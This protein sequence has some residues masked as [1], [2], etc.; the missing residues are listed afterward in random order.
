LYAVTAHAVGQRTP[1]IGLRMALGART[2]Q[3]VWIVVRK[4]MAQ[5]GLGLLA[6][7]VALVL[8]NHAFSGASTAAAGS[9]FGDPLTLLG[10]TVPLVIVTAIATAWPAFRASRIDPAIVLRSE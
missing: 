1:E 9:G 5:L 10:V 2:P 8:W 4:A 6:G 7:V 3:V